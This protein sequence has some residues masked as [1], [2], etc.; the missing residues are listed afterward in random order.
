MA[1]GGDLAA[2]LFNFFFFF[3]GGEGWREGKKG[4]GVKAGAGGGE[5]GK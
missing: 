1:N 3:L 2:A 4:R 5:T